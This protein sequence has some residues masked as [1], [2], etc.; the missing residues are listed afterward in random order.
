MNAPLRPAAPSR[1]GIAALVSAALA[2]SVASWWEM[3]AAYPQTQNG[4]GQF[5]YEMIDAMRVS[6]RDYHE[7][8]LWNPFQCGGVPLWDNPQ[9][10]SASPVLWA[11]LAP[12]LSTTH[13]IELWYI[14]HSA[15]GFV[16]MWLFARAELHASRSAAAVASIA[17]AFAGVHNQ[18]MTGGHLVWASF[19]YYPLGLLLWRRAERDVRYAIATGALVAWTMHE[20]G[21]YPL[22]YLALLL[23]LETLMRLRPVRRVGAILRASVVVVVVGFGLGAA[24][25]VPVVYQL[26]AHTRQIGAEHDALSLQTLH[27]MFLA[28]DHEREVPGQEYAWTEYGD[29]LG[30][31][32]LALAAVGVVLGGRQAL[33]MLPLLS[34]A[35]ALMLGHVGRFAPWSLLKGHVYPF[36]QMRV[37]SR[38]DALVTVFIPAYAAIAVDRLR[39]LVTRFVRRPGPRRATQALIVAVALGGAFDIVWVGVGF[40]RQ[41]FTSVPADARVEVSPRFYYGGPGLAPF[42]DQP[43]QHR[44]RL[45]CWEEWAFESTGALVQGDVPQ[46]RALDPRAVIRSVTRTPNR[47]V[48]DLAAP[49]PT[50]LLLN[51]TYA[52]GWRS[53][54]GTVQRSD[55]Q[56]AVAIPSGSGRIVV[57]Y[58]PEGLTA[59][60]V[61]SGVT[62]AG[63]LGFFVWRR[64][65]RSVVRERPRDVPV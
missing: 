55:G 42:L 34:I 22:V 64:Q 56:L 17:Y 28:K 15:A 3:L 23:G 7:L 38:F 43:A 26:H 41:F 4:D 20:G 61:G 16:C 1:L 50:T 39:G 45:E 53:S 25:F 37:P 14:V 33:W 46:A 18:H 40:G 9:G 30:P 24:R 13:A 11:L 19:L 60:F 10:V 62:M 47:F 29:Y 5:F 63:V 65:R 57:W 6:I 59:G 54:A 2:L 48:V 8:P 12:W 58:W 51:S 44:G 27:D 49:A 36:K 35:F 52:P 32:I 21:T 31:T